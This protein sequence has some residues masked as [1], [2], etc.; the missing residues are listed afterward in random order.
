MGDLENVA[1]RVTD[2]G[3]TVSVGRF[4]RLLHRECPGVERS[5]VGGIRIVNVDVQENLEWS[6]LVS[7]RD[8]HTR[9]SDIDLGRPT[10][11]DR[12]RRSEHGPQ[13]LHLRRHVVHDNSRRH[14]VEAFTG[15]PCVHG[16][17]YPTVRAS[18]APSVPGLPHD[19]GPAQMSLEAIACWQC[20]STP[21]VRRA[22]SDGS[23]FTAATCLQ[24][25]WETGESARS[26]VEEKSGLA[27]GKDTAPLR[28][29][30]SDAEIE[31]EWERWDAAIAT[32]SALTFVDQAI[33]S[34][35]ETINMTWTDDRLD[36]PQTDARVRLQHVRSLLV[37]S[38]YEEISVVT[39][40]TDDPA[41]TVREVPPDGEPPHWT[42]HIIFRRGRT[43]SEG[44]P[45]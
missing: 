7:R 1:K 20:G 42:T 29:H 28:P 39:T 41:L 10:R 33:S 15:T 43:H 45:A 27:Y 36:E 9:I 34:G 35:R 25:L 2:H 18:G 31:G 4:E 38:G 30:A 24:C 6:S 32:W 40:S 8:H 13:K 26:R 11:L 19:C 12:T 14:R 3:A 44:G 17:E 37:R 23:G 5:A 16:P 22:L 21:A